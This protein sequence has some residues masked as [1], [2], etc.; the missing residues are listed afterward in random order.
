VIERFVA[1][2]QPFDVSIILLETMQHKLTE[3]Q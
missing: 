3:L 2:L 1:P